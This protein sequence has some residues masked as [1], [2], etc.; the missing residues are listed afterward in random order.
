MDRTHSVC[1]ETESFNRRSAASVMQM[2]SVRGKGF[3]NKSQSTGF[4]LQR[5][6]Q[7]R[8]PSSAGVKLESCQTQISTCKKE[9]M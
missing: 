6:A 3:E 9:A 1:D 7:P 4:R 5:V 8:D 2:G